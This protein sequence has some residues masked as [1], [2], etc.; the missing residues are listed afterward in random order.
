[1]IAS[2]ENTIFQKKMIGP[3]AISSPGRYDKIINNEND[4]VHIS[5]L[6]NI[7]NSLDGVFGFSSTPAEKMDYGNMTRRSGEIG[8]MKRNDRKLCQD[9][10]NR[11]ADESQ[12]SAEE[13]KAKREEEVSSCLF[14]FYLVK[15]GC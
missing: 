6:S 7:V 12:L 4:Q 15:V 10:F 1:M 8:K 9:M 3:I 13:L 14:S 5:H 2:P 11:S